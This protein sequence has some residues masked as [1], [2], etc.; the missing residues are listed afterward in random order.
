MTHIVMF[1]VDGT[2][3]DSAGF[4]G[5]L[6][7]EAVRAV[8]GVDVDET[9]ASY[10]N[11]T[12]SG[13]LEQILAEREFERPLDELRSRVKGRFIELTHDYLVRHP[14]AVHEVSGARAFV[15]TLH[16]V[17]GIRVA[18]ATGGWRETA[19]LKLRGIGLN[20]DAL[21]IATASDTVE[22]SKI[23]QLAEQRAMNGIAPSKK[24]YFGDTVWDKRASAELGYRFIAIGGKVEHE[25]LFDDFTD[26]EAVLE[27]LAGLTGPAA[28]S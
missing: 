14:E 4:D 8:L 2:L 15:E 19:L 7:A 24:T 6:Y 23:M 5:H 18:V 20:V 25:T 26:R 12:D 1:D 16:T 3:V 9:W 21:A 22:R 17:P 27:C 28:P 13:V 11:V 10:A